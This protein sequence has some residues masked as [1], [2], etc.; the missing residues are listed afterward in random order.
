ML[1]FFVGWRRDSTP[2]SFPKKG[3]LVCAKRK[4]DELNETA[5]TTSTLINKRNRSYKHGFERVIRHLDQQKK[6][7]VIAVLFL[8]VGRR[9]STPVSFTKSGA[10]VCAERKPDELNET[11]NTTSALI[12]KRNRSYKHGFERVIPSPRPTKK[13]S[14]I[15][16]LFLLVGRRDSTPVSFTKS[17]ALVCILNDANLTS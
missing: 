8:L 6:D 4:P 17:G 14:V 9:D 1:S 10:L 2:V 13:D 16:V 5:D 11:A 7:S 12:N 15:A 3:A